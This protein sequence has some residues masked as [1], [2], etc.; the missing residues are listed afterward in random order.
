MGSRRT[1]NGLLRLDGVVSSK[2][3]DEL[4][5]GEGVSLYGVIGGES[6][7]EADSAS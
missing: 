6:A 2:C 4:E 7:F 5:R 3:F 1:E